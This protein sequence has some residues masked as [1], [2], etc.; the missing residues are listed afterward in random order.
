MLSSIL[1]HPPP[2]HVHS[3]CTGIIRVTHLIRYPSSS[4]FSRSIWLAFL[5]EPLRAPNLTLHL[6]RGVYVP[7]DSTFHQSCFQCW[8]SGL[9]RLTNNTM[10]VRRS[11]DGF[12][13]AWVF[14]FVRSRCHSPSHCSPVLLSFSCRRAYTN[15][16]T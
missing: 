11:V 6:A 4:V 7:R 14:S 5:P 10:I 2:C 13:G 9:E 3:M 16:V 15:T 8:R 12:S 1:R